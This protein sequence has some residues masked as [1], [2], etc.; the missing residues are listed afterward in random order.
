V[1]EIDELSS[2]F[3]YAVSTYA[4]TGSQGSFSKLQSD[5]LTR[6]KILNLNNPIVVGFGIHNKQTIDFAHTYAQGAIIGTAFINS[7]KGEETL[8][9]DIDLF[10]KNLEVKKLKNANT[11]KK[12]LFKG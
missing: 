2:P 12:Y 11:T 6:L 4:I 10:F 3:I 8:G 9:S 7:L 1:R 5:Y